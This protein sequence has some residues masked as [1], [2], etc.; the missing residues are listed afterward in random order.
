MQAMALGAPLTQ[1]AR[2][3]APVDMSV[4]FL[5]AI[6]SLNPFRAINDPA[7]VLMGLIYDY[8]FSL[9]QDGNLVPNVAL[10][11]TCDA[12]CM[13]WTYQIRQGVLWHDGTPLT[14]V[15]VAFTINYNIQ[16]FF[17]L[18]AFEPYVNRIIQCSSATRPYCG[19]AVTSPWNVT[20]Y[21]DRP[22]V[23]GKALFI[24]IIQEAQW[25]SISASQAQ[26]QFENANPIGTGP[27]I[28]DA[29]IFDRWSTAQPLLVH[30][31][32]NYHPVGS[33]VGP[34]FIDN[35]Y[36][37]Q[38]ADENTLVAAVRAGTIQL[39][40]MTS[41]GYGA[42]GGLAG[43]ERQ[44]TLPVTHYS[45][46]IGFQQLS[47]PPVNGKLN[48]TRWDEQVRR[49]LA[50]ATNK[51]YV[52]QT[53]Y[54]GKGVRG[55][56]LM[57][58][59][60]P[61]WFYDPTQ[62]TGANLTF[63]LAAANALL[64]SAGYTDRVANPNVPGGVRAAAADRTFVNTNG[65]LVTIPAGTQISFTMATR[66]EFPQ[67]YQTAL[68]LRAE[69]ARVGVL[70]TIKN[71]L[72]SALSAD[73]YDGAVET[74]IWYWSGDP[75]PNYLLSCESGYTLDG[76]NDN[77][78]DNATYN[79][80]YVDHLAATD[81]VQRQQI[82]R[83]A[84]KL[85]Y[86]SAVYIIY[87]YPYG[88]WAYRTDHFS[89]WG[90]WNAHPYRQI[91]AFWGANPLFFD[92]QQGTPPVDNPPTKPVIAG[93]ATVTAYVNTTVSFS[94]SSTDPDPG[95]TL[96]WSWNWGNGDVTIHTNDSSI[97]EDSASY[98]WGTPG[99]YTVTLSVSDGQLSATSD[100]VTVTV[101]QPTTPLGW[102]NGTVKDSGGN[103]ISGAAVT[104]NP[105]SSTGA[106]NATGV[107]SIVVPNGTYS[108]TASKYLY[109]SHTL[110]N[111]VV[112]ADGTAWANF[113]LTPNN[114][115]IAGTVTNSADS[116]P[117]AGAAVYASVSGV[118]VA[119]DLTDSQGH[120]NLSIA[121]GTF[122]MNANATGFHTKNATGVAVLS[123]A[124]TTQNFALDPV[125][126]PPTGLST[127]VVVTIALVVVAAAAILIF[128]LMRRRKKK[129]EQGRIELPP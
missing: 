62:E 61:Q 113:T 16:N 66:L 13:N 86:Q 11:A 122:S 48:P 67:E 14:A 1:D 5:E 87:I 10:D 19:A 52:I 58:P 82:T 29:N 21:F 26:Y 112:P 3:A 68:Y 80:L 47:S 85:H 35:L 31:N 38:F 101:V 117:I 15:D 53:I 93:S 104:T 73:V 79:Q 126:V 28:A 106:S 34:A 7:Y 9:D 39:A 92:L 114:G 77:Y 89:G 127:L 100:P 99:T 108:A 91:D 51:D 111:L 27:F 33:H 95:Q 96:A 81:P 84:E 110:A 75:D 4:G 69:W 44:E 128:Y 49:A 50:M 42:L 37:Q 90:D 65:E 54:Q 59:V 129:D 64:D 32:P 116:S 63:D 76:W 46:E 60:T 43:I 78:W 88:E 12:V 119:T 98:A 74:Y 107:Y 8:L 125:V 121:P 97:T 24:P 40:K 83:Q 72:E 57:S 55:T 22:F 124:T 30:K 36:L 45:L 23:P 71:E 56:S 109:S 123:G 103:P 17:Q 2:A 18:W 25:R 115:W 105:G 120:Y 94:G 20:V 41:A 102:I 70:L 118:P 6:D